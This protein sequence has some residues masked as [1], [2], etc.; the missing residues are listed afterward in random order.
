VELAVQ[1]PNNAVKW[2]SSDTKSMKCHTKMTKATVDTGDIDLPLLVCSLQSRL[3]EM[4]QTKV[5]HKP[6][7]RTHSYSN[8]NS[9]HRQ[10]SSL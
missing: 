2:K 1:N 4:E 5:H 8:N 7:V 6:N 9:F 10:P 3:K